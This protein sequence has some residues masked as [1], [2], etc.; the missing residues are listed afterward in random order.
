MTKNSSL[1]DWVFN[2]HDANKGISRTLAEGIQTCVFAGEQAMLSVVK[3]E[4]NSVGKIHSHPEEQWG[5]LL[6]GDCIRQQGDEEFAMKVGDFWHTPGDVPHTIRAGAAGAL[7]LD[8]F[9]PPRQEYKRSGDGFGQAQVHTE[10][11][12]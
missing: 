11:T 2:L 8:I 4:P 5:V 7:V 9:S 12:E 6:E 3:F 1:P 10:T